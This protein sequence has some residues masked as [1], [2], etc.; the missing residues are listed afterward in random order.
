MKNNLSAILEELSNNIMFRLS[1]GSKELFH[2]N[3]WAWLLEKYEDA[4]KIFGEECIDKDSVRREMSH[5]DLSFEHDGKLIIIEN[6]FKSYPSLEQLKKYA[7]KNQANFSHI[8][9]VSYFEPTFLSDE[10]IT[11]KEN[12]F[13]KF[14]GK[15][16]DK[17]KNIDLTFEFKYLSYK[18][19]S[20][21][22][23]KFV[24]SVSNIEHKEYIEKYIKMLND[25][26]ELKDYLSME[27]HPDKS[28]G[29]FIEEMKSEENIKIAKSFNFDV[30]IQKIFGWNLM[31]SILNQIND[32][33]NSYEFWCD[34]GRQHV[35]MDILLKTPNLDYI[36]AMGFELFCEKEN[37]ISKYMKIAL[38]K[39]SD[40][41]YMTDIDEDFNKFFKN[42]KDRSIGK[43][44]KFLGYKDTN[45]LYAWLYRICN[46][47]IN[48]MKFDDLVE[49]YK[50]ELRN[51]KEYND[52]PKDKVKN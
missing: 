40:I 34:R 39:E 31:L 8:I 36:K 2:S 47:N 28:F 38:A 4:A 44:K 52:N 12:N 45:A 41:Q 51:I 49:L 6:K 5:T 3:F 22:L 30:T 10:K 25:L 26:I 19:L 43:D 32:D 9:L 7:Y 27:K 29:N 46:F 13:Y 48:E 11:K 15:Y 23:Q 18:N 20:D 14:E 21:N 24:E 1:L 35:Y 17:S 50:K 33:K 37:N 16:E 42:T